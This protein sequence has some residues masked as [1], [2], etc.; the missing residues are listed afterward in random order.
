MEKK[1]EKLVE[2]TN[3]ENGFTKVMSEKDFYKEFG[4]A[5]GQNLIKGYHPSL[6]AILL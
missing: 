3:C 2:V 5:T 1:K 6:V 4:R